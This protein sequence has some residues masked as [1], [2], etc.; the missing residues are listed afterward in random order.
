MTDSDLKEVRFDRWCKS[1][2]HFRRPQAQE[3][4]NQCLTKGMRFGTE[5]PEQYKERSK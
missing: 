2:E 3:P 4:C 5:K 1:C